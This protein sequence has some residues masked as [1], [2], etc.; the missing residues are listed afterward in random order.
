M[1]V[2]SL[3][4]MKIAKVLAVSLSLGVCSSAFSADELTP[5][6]II[7][8][9][10]TN[11]AQ[12]ISKITVSNFSPV[13]LAVYDGETIK[14]ASGRN[15]GHLLMDLRVLFAQELGWINGLQEKA[16]THD[17]D[18]VADVA[19]Q[20]FDAFNWVYNLA[21]ADAKGDNL[22]KQSDKAARQTWLAKTLVDYGIV[23]ESYRSIYVAQKSELDAADT[24][25]EKELQAKLD[26]DKAAKDAERVS[27]NAEFDARQ[28]ELEGQKARLDAVLAQEKNATRQSDTAQ[29]VKDLETQ[30]QALSSERTAYNT[31]IDT[32]VALLES[33]FSATKTTMQAAKAAALKQLDDKYAYI[34]ESL[35]TSGGKTL[36]RWWSGRPTVRSE[37]PEFPELDRMLSNDYP[38][39]PGQARNSVLDAVFGLIVPQ[40]EADTANTLRKSKVIQ[41]LLGISDAEYA[42][43]T[44]RV[45]AQEL[46][47]NAA[48][49]KKATDGAQAVKD[50]I[51]Q[52]LSAPAS[53]SNAPQLFVE[54]KP[55]A[56]T[57]AEASAAKAVAAVVDDRLEGQ[58]KKDV[59][60]DS[61]DEGVVPAS[62]APAGLAG[63]YRLAV[64]PTDESFGLRQRITPGASSSAADAL[65]GF[66]TP[67]AAGASPAASIAPDFRSTQ[68]PAHAAQKKN[69]QGKSGQNNRRGRGR[70]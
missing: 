63:G 1:N 61:D 23:A 28:K 16:R 31:S 66:G 53:S 34:F 50:G 55:A 8:R 59:V 49:A 35:G 11:D 43:I 57:A 25:K 30:L 18:F 41:G 39:L 10:R 17:S 24:Q 40:S 52:A 60:E 27:K 33:E 36:S 47:K 13:K 4:V 51:V 64:N 68:Q 44:E 7:D 15:F 2:S 32:A 69:N 45:H 54:A 56:P 29:S 46:A 19:T 21:S 26:A 65:R 9:V 70:H 42:S 22:S 58:K 12:Q 6:T 48:L 3:N 20:A 37:Y 5:Q 38:T 67:F 14:E 62:S